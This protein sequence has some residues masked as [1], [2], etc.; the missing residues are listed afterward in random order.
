MTLNRSQLLR[1]TR[2]RLYNLQKKLYFTIE[3]CGSYFADSTLFCGPCKWWKKFRKFQPSED[4]YARA[5]RRALIGLTFSTED[6]WLPGRMSRTSSRNLLFVENSR[7][8]RAQRSSIAR[9]QQFVSNYRT[10]ARKRVSDPRNPCAVL[11]NRAR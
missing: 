5:P 6:S 1:D 8:A 2:Q 3:P 10:I 4:G 7:A 11:G 9:S